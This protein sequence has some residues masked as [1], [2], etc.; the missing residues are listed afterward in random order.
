MFLADNLAY[1]VL[2][3]LFSLWLTST[4]PGKT[5]KKIHLREKFSNHHHV[6]KPT[7]SRFY[8]HNN[9]F[10]SHT[11]THKKNLTADDM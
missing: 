8:W 2:Y 6:T 9:V 1:N 5:S 10:A 7:Y 3:N 11:H 4:L